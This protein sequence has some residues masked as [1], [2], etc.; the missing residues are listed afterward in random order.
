MSSDELIN[1]FVLQIGKDKEEIGRRG[2]NSVER[3]M[4]MEFLYRFCTITQPEIGRIVGIDYSAVSQARR[5]LKGR[6]WAQ[7]RPRLLRRLERLF[8]LRL[9]PVQPGSRATE[10]C[11]DHPG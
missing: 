3:A 10:H 7:G 2:R 4:L 1:R 11:R 8:D 6:V 5:S 9:Q